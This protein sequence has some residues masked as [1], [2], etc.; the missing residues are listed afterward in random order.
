M[1]RNLKKIGL[2]L[3]AAIAICLAAA[4]AAPAANFTA[5][6]YPATF[7]AVQHAGVHEFKMAGTG[8]TCASA[9][10]VSHAIPGPS[11]DLT[12]TTGYGECKDT[13][14]GLSATVTSNGCLDTLTEPSVVTAQHFTGN[15]DLVCPAGRHLEIH[16]ATC[17]ITITPKNDLQNITYTNQP[18]ALPK[19]DIT[20]D[21]NVKGLVYEVH[22]GF[23]CPIST[24]YDTVEHSDGELIGSVT[25][26]AF[27][28]VGAQ[29]GADVG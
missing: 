11:P 12:F 4:S 13:T 2:T 15:L 8:V 16:L 28:N 5:E 24:T 21:I 20:L 1:T 18:S 19:K 9:H 26:K 29:Q 14:F 22:R 25:M 6:T 27:N 17:T 7:T 3:S 10:L 23:L